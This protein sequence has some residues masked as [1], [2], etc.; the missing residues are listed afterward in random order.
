MK[1]PVSRVVAADRLTARRVRPELRY[2]HTRD[3]WRIALYHYAHERAPGQS[4]VMLCHGLGANRFNVDAPGRYSLARYLY[5]RGNDVWVVELRGAGRSRRARGLRRTTWDWNFDDHVHHDVPAALRAIR[6][7]TGSDDVHWVGHSMGGMVGYA[8]LTVADQHHLRSLVAI[9]SP[10]FSGMRSRYLDAALLMRGSLH[11]L[12]RLPYRT[13]SRL[14]LP[15]VLAWARTSD[16]LAN[17]DNMDPWLLTRLL[18]LAIDDVPTSLLAQFLDWYVTHDFRGWYGTHSYKCGLRDI[19]V[20]VHIIAGA[21]DRL[22]PPHDLRYVYDHL[23]SV[24]KKFTLVGRETGFSADYG[25]IDL[26]LGKHAPE[27]V[28][29]LVA[30]WIATH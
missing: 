26:V 10:A 5:H 15:A 21:A 29:P 1:P 3:G 14:A 11:V 8:F 30:D 23:A 12:K 6:E 16:L 25:H 7:W 19:R 20:P 13:G 28:F 4:P 9:A 24:D 27:E 22:T 2:A 18:W 17:P